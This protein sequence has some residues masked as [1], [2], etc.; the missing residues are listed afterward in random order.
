MEITSF[1]PGE[2]RQLPPKLS[3]RAAVLVTDHAGISLQPKKR[4]AYHSTPTGI[5]RFLVDPYY[6]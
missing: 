3:G 6:R 1:Q 2:I 5:N 4:V